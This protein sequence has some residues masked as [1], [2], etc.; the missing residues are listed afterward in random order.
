MAV[1]SPSTTQ[2]ERLN[3]VDRLVL[4]ADAF[5]RKQ[6]LPGLPC[7][8]HVW[9]HGR[10]DLDELQRNVNRLVA[11]WPL[12]SARL[13][14][15]P[16]PA[17]RPTGESTSLLRRTSVSSDC[18]DDLLRTAENLM[19]ERFDLSRE[20]PIRFHVLHRPGGDDALIVQYAHALMDAHGGSVLS[21]QL[22]DPSRIH[23]GEP[24]PPTATE[25]PD[26]LLREIPRKERLRALRDVVRQQRGEKVISL[27]LAQDPAIRRALSR[28]HLRWIDGD[29]ASA[30]EDRM[31]RM[32]MLANLSLALAAS[33]FR[34]LHRHLNPTP[35][36]GVYD[37]PLPY[38]V[39]QE[40]NAPHPFHNHAAR[41]MLR[42]RPDQLDDWEKLVWQFTEQMMAQSTPAARLGLL[43]AASMV[44]TINRW[45]PWFDKV[46]EPRGR[47]LR[48]AYWLE[49]FG[50]GHET[51]GAQIERRFG[52]TVCPATPGVAVDVFRQGGRMLACF[53]RHPAALTDEQAEQFFDNWIEDLAAQAR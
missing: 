42:A 47:S 38:K 3:L 15:K 13:V 36:E 40:Q 20:A 37:M 32:G 6:G 52:C 33:G 53:T 48:V 41:V 11:H 9:L 27:P 46:L 50:A 23:D 24:P 28:I 21:Q 17:W 31:R 18:E 51:H 16:F 10:L 19:A 2:L 30:L 35:T 8:H 45:L 25:M 22:V 29:I 43:Q 1:D 4:A 34:T 7:Q 44:A 12:L 14:R 49:A 39:R 5:L 26:R